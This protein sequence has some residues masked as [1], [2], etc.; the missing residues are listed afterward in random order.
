MFIEIPISK[1][2]HMINIYYVI[3][4]VYIHA[5]Q[6]HPGCKKGAGPIRS[7][8][9]YV[10]PKGLISAEAKITLIKDVSKIY[11]SIFSQV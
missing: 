9:T 8:P 1:Y 5:K 6:K 7:S 4:H 10:R 11:N 3:L 2:Y